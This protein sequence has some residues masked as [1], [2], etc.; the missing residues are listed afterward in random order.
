VAEGRRADAVGMHTAARIAAVL[1]AVV[2]LNVALHFAPW[3]DV[4]LD[5]PGW[6]HTVVRVKNWLLLA[7]LVLVIVGIALEDNRRKGD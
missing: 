1:A 2:V 4:S 7:V 6:I 3:P 5:V